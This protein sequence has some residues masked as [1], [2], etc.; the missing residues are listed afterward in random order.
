MDRFYW[1]VT[2]QRLLPLKTVAFRRKRASEEELH[3]LLQSVWSCLDCLWRGAL[4]SSWGLCTGSA[5]LCSK[6]KYTVGSAC[7]SVGLFHILLGF[8]QFLKRKT[9][10][11]CPG[12]NCS[13]T[14]DWTR[15]LF[16][17]GKSQL[18]VRISR[19]RFSEVRLD[20]EFF[21][22]YA[23]KVGG[24]ASVIVR[25]T[26]QGSTVSSRTLKMNNHVRF[27]CGRLAQ[28]LP[29]C[30]DCAGQ[31]CGSFIQLF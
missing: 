6:H 15:P 18:S 4:V 13:S 24:H 19:V 21:S 14:S 8:Q 2:A 31:S 7:G 23:S 27:V 30:W 16:H 12:S 1:R 29:L 25:V 20:G 10:C 22:F 5:W 17:C 3:A 26:E 28:T 9:N 11:L